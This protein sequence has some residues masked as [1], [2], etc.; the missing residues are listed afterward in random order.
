[1]ILKLIIF[2]ILALIVY[3]FVGGKLPSLSGRKDDKLSSKDEKKKIE[4]DTLIECDKCSTFVTYKES[5]IVKSKVYCSK[6][7]A[8]F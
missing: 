1:M 8:G 2:T 5:I 4:E 3:K 7:C 6:E